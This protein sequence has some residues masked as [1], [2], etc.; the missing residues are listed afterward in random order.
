MPL[1]GDGGVM[2]PRE[3]DGAMPLRGFGG[4]KPSRGGGGAMSLGAEGGG[5]KPS[6]S[7]RVGVKPT[8]KFVV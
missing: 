4:V 3:D 1:E 8:T 6:S 5:A 7:W 2:L